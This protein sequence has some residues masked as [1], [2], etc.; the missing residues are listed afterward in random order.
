MPRQQLVEVEGLGE[1]VV[2]ADFQALDLVLERVHGGQHQD[3]GVVAFMPQPLAHVI[4]V[5]VWQHQ[6]E[7]DHVELAGLGK[8]DAFGAGR[9]RR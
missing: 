7:H 6:V 4:A 1:I 8:L 5:H 9:P 2:G 3:R